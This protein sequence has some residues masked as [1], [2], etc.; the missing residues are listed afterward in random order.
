MKRK[1]E[2]VRNNPGIY[3]RLEFD[4]LKGKWK[5]TGKYRAIRRITVR[6]LSIKEQGVFDNIEDAKAFR[7]GLIQ[8][9]S[10]GSQ[11]HKQSENDPDQEYLFATLVD[12]WKSLHF[13]QIE[14]TSQQM[15]E[16]RLP[17][18]APLERVE[19]KN[20]NTTVI[21]NL[22]K[23]WLNPKFPKAKDRQTFEKELDLLKV[24]LNFYRRHKNNNYFL[25]IL[26]EH[27][28]AA[29][30]AKMPKK[31]VRGLREDD[32]G[33]FLA[34][35]NENYPNFYPIAL[36]QLGLGLRIGEALGLCWE[37]FDLRRREVRV[38]RNIAWNKATRLMTAKK[39]KNARIL[40][41]AL[42]EFLVKILEDLFSKRDLQSPYL[43]VREGELIRRQQVAKAYNR[44]LEKLGIDHLSGTHVLRKTSGT[45]A[46]KLTRDVYA[47][48]KLL[49]HSSVNIT[50]RYYQEQ[51]DEDKRM[52]A[53]ALNTVLTQANEQHSSENRG[54]QLTTCPPVSPQNRFPKLK[55][56]KS[57]S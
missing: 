45:L 57:S 26:P 35:M 15:Y 10:A 50:E 43:F 28:R 38:A 18:L 16:G 53:E 6:G 47:A 37:D 51:L 54:A 14:Y 12:E 3:R 44:T 22:V 21:T 19:V 9:V 7:L 34:S 20:I 25:P 41:A 48:S 40:E 1:E 33:R 11:V 5:D 55:L 27:Y 52:V 29:D 56:I 30:F 23:H 8:K 17:N 36:L 42:P 13:L 39:R 49:D 46:R 32:L 2:P 31:P 24:I 4:E